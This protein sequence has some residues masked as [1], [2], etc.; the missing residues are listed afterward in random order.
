MSLGV[1]VIERILERNRGWWGWSCVFIYPPSLFLSLH[2]GLWLE[3]CG[4]IGLI[5]CR[6]P[7]IQVGLSNA[8]AKA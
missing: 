5:D 1:G 8:A 4:W 7:F 6:R 3:S 2:T